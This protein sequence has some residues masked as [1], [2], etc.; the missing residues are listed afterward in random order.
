MRRGKELH[1]EKNHLRL[2]IEPRNIEDETSIHVEKIFQQFCLICHQVDR[3]LVN[4]VHLHALGCDI[5]VVGF[6]LTRG[7]TLGYYIIYII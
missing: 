6:F 4:L 7:G 3:L 1:E 2:E 5:L